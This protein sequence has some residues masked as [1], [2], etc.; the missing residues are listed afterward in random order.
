MKLFFG[1]LLM[2]S[3]IV[4]EGCSD[5]GKEPTE[6]PIDTPTTPS[7]ISFRQQIL[8]VFQRYGCESCH[9]G[10][11]GLFL[12]SV[13]NLSTGGDHGPAINIAEPDSSLILKKLSPAP[14]F[15]DRMPQGGPYLPD[16]TIHLIR[17][18][19]LQGA[20]DN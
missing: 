14:P 18:W 19:I 13:A 3:I 16:S 17:S 8:P 20:Q 9:G 5:L 2:T 6:A 4:C 11:G 1:A 7:S 12:Q 10:S 15:G